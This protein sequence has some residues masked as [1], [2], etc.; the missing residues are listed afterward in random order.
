MNRP[1]GGP[2]PRHAIE[3]DGDAWTD[4]G[5]QVVSGA[6]RVAERTRRARRS[7]ATARG[8]HRPVG[9]RRR[10]AYVRSAVR[11]AIEP[12][13]RDD[14]DIVTVRYTPKLA[15]LVPEGVDDAHVGRRDVVRVHRVR[16]RGSRVA[17]VDVR[18]ALAH[19]GGSRAPRRGRAD[20][21]RRRD[22][23]DRAPRA[24]GAHARTSPCGSIPT[25]PAATWELRRPAVTLAIGGIETW[26]DDASC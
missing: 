6:F 25:R 15:D 24:P 12:Y 19:R 13:E 9:Q 16:S 21:P 23:W 10:C 20:Q 3:A 14:L 4:A 2:Q 18:R 7:R 5:R 26:D 8:E 22:R 1:D 11:D 17:D